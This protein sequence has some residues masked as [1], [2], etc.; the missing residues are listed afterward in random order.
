MNIYHWIIIAIYLLGFLVTLHKNGQ[1]K[2][3]THYD[4]AGAFY[5]SAILIALTIL[6]A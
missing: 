2:K 5:V 6:S 4:A 1:L 3:E